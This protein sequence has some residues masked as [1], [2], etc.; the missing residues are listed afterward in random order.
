MGQVGDKHGGPGAE[1]GM[2][3]LQGR[4]RK[5]WLSRAKGAAREGTKVSLTTPWPASERDALSAFRSKAQKGRSVCV[6]EGGEGW[7]GRVREGR[8]PREAWEVRRV[9]GRG[10]PPCLPGAGQSPGGT[11]NWH[12]ELLPAPYVCPPPL[13]AHLG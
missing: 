5:T 2:G 3:P 10:S 1:S 12:G 11:L 6:E 9:H 8:R 4:N 13:L 7:C